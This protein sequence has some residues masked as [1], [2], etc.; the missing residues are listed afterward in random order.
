MNGV[1][2]EKLQARSV[3]MSDSRAA[4]PVSSRLMQDDLIPEREYLGTHCKTLSYP[5]QWPGMAKEK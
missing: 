1:E 4:E 5:G 2:K 3:T